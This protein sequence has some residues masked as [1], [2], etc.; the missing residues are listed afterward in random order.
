MRLDRAACVERVRAARVARL[1]TTRAD[2]RVDLV[3]C[4]FALDP[5]ESSLVGVVDHKPKATARLQRLDNIAARPDVTLLV[6][7]YDED[8]STL[9]WVR[10]RG[11][12]RVVEPATAEHGELVELLAAKYPHYLGAGRPT[13]PGIR[14]QVTEWHGWS[15]STH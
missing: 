11:L 1:A 10:I 4:V 5:D 2:G 3:P 6:D 14:V 9:W 12:A 7:H 15:A 8:W 13:G